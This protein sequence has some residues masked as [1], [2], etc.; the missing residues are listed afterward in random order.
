[1]YICKPCGAY[2]GCYR[3]TKKALG[4]L[5]NAELRKCKHEAHEAFD[6]IWGKGYMGR[7]EAYTWL[8]QQLGTDRNLTHIGMFDVEKCKKVIEASRNYLKE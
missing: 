8:S 3:G 6:Q 7:K 4:R 2:V 5:A 1:M